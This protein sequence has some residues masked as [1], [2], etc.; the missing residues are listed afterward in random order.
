[1]GREMR[2]PGGI[3]VASSEEQDGEP[4]GHWLGDRMDTWCP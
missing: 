1:M 2:S 3:A 4:F